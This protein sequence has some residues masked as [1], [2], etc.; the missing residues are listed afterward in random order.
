MIGCSE[1]YSSFLQW[2][3][4]RSPFNFTQVLEEW[5][6]AEN[7]NV[8]L[9][10]WSNCSFNYSVWL[11]LNKLVLSGFYSLWFHNDLSWPVLSLIT[12]HTLYSISSLDTDIMI[13]G[14]LYRK[15][16][17]HQKL[18]CLPAQAEILSV[19]SHRNIIQFYGA[20]VEAP[21]YGIVTGKFL[22]WC[23]II[24]QH[25]KQ[26]Y[27]TTSCWKTQQLKFV[28]TSWTVCSTLNGS[29]VSMG[30]FVNARRFRKC[31]HWYSI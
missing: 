6:F 10:L 17:H 1:N 15:T 20:I 12:L 5:L 3:S 24:K 19:L 7:N 2:K 4:K 29:E 18:C 8:I 22:K 13:C 27:W 31:T 11:Q 26:I 23:L 30:A 21:N 16:Y 9:S 25:K 14:L 28:C